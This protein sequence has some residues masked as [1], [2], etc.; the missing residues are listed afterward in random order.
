MPARAIGKTAK[1][2]Q[3]KCHSAVAD[4]VW[5]T[6]LAAAALRGEM[7]WSGFALEGAM[8]CRVASLVG[9]PRYN[10]DGLWQ[11]LAQKDT[12]CLCH[13]PTGNKRHFQI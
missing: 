1:F 12:A 11:T 9:R 3:R 10:T 6:L 4:T 7:T 13:D 2:Q 5:D 8:I